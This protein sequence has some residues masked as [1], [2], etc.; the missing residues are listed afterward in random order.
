MDEVQPKE[1]TKKSEIIVAI[2]ICIIAA[3]AIAVIFT[4][5]AGEASNQQTP[6]TP[7]GS[8][9]TSVYS[10]ITA[11]AAYDLIN[12]TVNLSVIDCRCLDG[13]GSCQFNHGHL[14]GAVLFLPSPCTVDEQEFRNALVSHYNSTNDILVY[15]KDGTNGA[16]FCKELVGH[17]YGKIYNLEG[18]YTAW[19]KFMEP[20]P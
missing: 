6:E 17:V 15:S 9:Y 20:N 5:P 7:V 16:S 12:N 14:P 18:G 8:K 4:W 3:A 11:G 19:E 13:C 10:N 2:V 1:G